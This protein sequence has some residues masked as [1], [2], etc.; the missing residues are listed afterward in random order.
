[1][2]T[3]LSKQDVI[4]RIADAEGIPKA[5]ANRILDQTLSIIESTMAEGGSVTF[6]GFGTFT[7]SERQART[8]RNPQTG[9]PIQIAA[10]TVPKFKAG[11]GLKDAVN[12]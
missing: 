3:K 4:D 1:M 2:A 9:E 7:V 10:A 11:K 8:G 6:V 12:K 5:S